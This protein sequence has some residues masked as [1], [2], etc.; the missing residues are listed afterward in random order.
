MPSVSAFPDRVVP[1]RALVALRARVGG[2]VICPDDDE[3]AA[4]SAVWNRDVQRRPAVVVRCIRSDDVAAAIEFARAAKLPLAIRGG[5]LSPAGMSTCDGV[6]LDMRQ[7]HNVSVDPLGRTAVVAAGASW[8]AVDVATQRFG[9]AI[10]GV[11]VSYIGV[12]G[13]TMGGGFGYLRRAYGLA[14]D[15]LVGADLVT[16]EGRLVTTSGDMHPE[17]LWGL[18][19]GGGNFGVVTSLRFRLLPLPE[20]VLSGSVIYRADHASALLGFYRDYTAQLRDD[21]TTK[22]SLFSAA[23]SP[24]TAQALGLAPAV[25]VIAITAACV[26][27]PDD[28]E[29]LV[30]PIRDAAPVL[31]DRI[32]AQPYARLQA[33]PDSAYSP[34]R[35]A[36]VTSCYVDELYDDLIAGLSEAHAAMP[37]GSCEV[38]VHHMGGAVGRVAWMST[39]VPNRAARYLISVMARW[40]LPGDEA[41]NRDWLEATEKTIRTFGVGGPHIGLQSAPTSSVEAYGAE[42]YLRLAALK[43]RFDPDNVFAGNQNVAPLA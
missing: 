25:P 6:V 31:R 39:A 10:P 24:A 28:S 2:S 9:Y 15:S 36:A 1:T 37:Y 40:D 35:Y 8:G 13:S 33:S 42:R 21:V 32:A 26:G 14:C 23:H 41:A 34:G 22:L 17:L 20:P 38:H 11:P 12:A 43:R 18:R 16:A 29:R 27:H 3:Y 30:R 7:M 19:G 4:L 5:G